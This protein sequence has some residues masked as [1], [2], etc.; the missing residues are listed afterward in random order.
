MARKEPLRRRLRSLDPKVEPRIIF[1]LERKD[2]TLFVKLAGE[3]DMLGS[4]K[5][6]SVLVRK[7]NGVTKVIF[8]IS[9]L[10]FADSYFLRLLLKL[11]KRLGGVSSVKVK[12]PRPNVKKLF[13]ITGLDKLFL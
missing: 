13:E 9:D 7:L 8:D 5:L 11:R 1:G 3:A 6:R 2:K 10:E 12:N 4:S